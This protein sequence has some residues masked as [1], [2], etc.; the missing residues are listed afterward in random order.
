MHFFGLRKQAAALGLLSPATR[1]FVATGRKQLGFV[2]LGGATLEEKAAVV[3]FL[4]L[5]QDGEGA[6]FCFTSCF[7]GDGN[8]ATDPEVTQQAAAS[9]GDCF[10]ISTPTLVTCQEKH[11]HSKYFRVKKYTGV[12]CFGPA[13]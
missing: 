8:A 7:V 12:V 1:D 3:V 6:A 13:N 9:G 11:L 5:P 4:L 2:A 10:A